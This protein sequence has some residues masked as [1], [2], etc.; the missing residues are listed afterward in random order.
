MA[1]DIRQIVTFDAKPAEIYRALMDAKQHAAFT[2]ERAKN[3]GK[4]GGAFSHYGGYLVGVNVELVKGTRIVQAWRG[5]DWPK[6]AYSIARFDL[7]AVGTG[8]TKVTFTQW[9]VPAEQLVRIG[10]GWKTYY[11]DPLAAWLKKRK[12]AAPRA[13]TVKSAPRSK[14]K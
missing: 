10:Q 8:Q 12:R 1:H 6:G 4:V 11:W 5:S 9:G 7:A 13:K 14:R 3:D 2:G